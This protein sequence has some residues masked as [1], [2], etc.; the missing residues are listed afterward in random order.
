MRY[1][2]LSVSL[3]F[4]MMSANLAAAQLINEIPRSGDWTGSIVKTDLNQKRLLGNVAFNMNHAYEVSFTSFGGQAYNQNMY[5]NTM[6]FGFNDRLTGRLDLSMAHSPFGNGLMTQ[7]N[8]MRFMVRNAEL[9]YRLG[10]NSNVSVSFSQM[11]YGY[12]GSPSD[13]YGFGNHSFRNRNNPW[14]AAGNP[15]SPIY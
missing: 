11:P 15:F 8:D 13:R 1:I 14:S 7:G 12:Y 9:N 3:L 2:V 4:L 10:Q 6:L 5:T